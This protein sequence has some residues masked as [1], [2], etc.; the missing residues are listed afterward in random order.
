MAGIEEAFEKFSDR[1][2]REESKRYSRDEQGDYVEEVQDPYPIKLGPLELGANAN[3]VTGKFSPNEYQNVSTMNR[4]VG[5][6][7]KY[8]VP[9]SGIS[10]LGS[11]GDV[12]S[13]QNVRTDLPFNPMT[14]EAS[15]YSEMRKDVYKDSPYSVGAQYNP[16]GTDEMYS[17]LYNKGGGYNLGY[18]KGPVN[19]S[20]TSNP[21]L[22]NNVMLR[23]QY[24]FA[25]GGV[26]SMFRERPGYQVGGTI[27]PLA[28]QRSPIDQYG[29][30][31]PVISALTGNI[32]TS[33]QR[34]RDVFNPQAGLMMQQAQAAGYSEPEMEE[35]RQQQDF[36][37]SFQRSLNEAYF[38]PTF[39]ADPQK[40]AIDLA[41]SIYNQRFQAPPSVQQQRP[42][43]QYQYSS[44]GTPIL[45]YGY[46]GIPSVELQSQIDLQKRALDRLESIYNKPMAN[47]GGDERVHAFGNTGGYKYNQ[48]ELLQ[49]ILRSEQEAAA[50]VTPKMAYGGRVS[51]SEG[52]L[53]TTV[54]PAKGPDSQ[55]VESLFRRRYS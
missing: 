52:G 1:L 42:Q 10:L 54:P 21:G 7:G 3:M 13:N 32:F 23:G 27:D 6:R 28:L 20:Y 12:R 9:D 35:L 34:F 8:N 22:G 24:N 53:T 39:Q 49:N 33:G 37:P 46:T 17:A 4:N 47:I 48:N 26:A 31:D 55:G 51:M 5:L 50:R 14:G 45:Q 41:T 18:N 44:K 25:D 38:G 19:V 29:Y 43:T 30:S 11:I 40:S 15:P 2:A 16:Q 36:F